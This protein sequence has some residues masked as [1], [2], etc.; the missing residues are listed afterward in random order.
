[1]ILGDFLLP[2]KND[3]SN[4]HKNIPISFNM[5]QVLENNFMMINI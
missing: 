1:M 2:Q 5:Y 4:A 3:D